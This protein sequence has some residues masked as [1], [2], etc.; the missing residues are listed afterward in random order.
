MDGASRCGPLHPITSA[1]LAHLTKEGRPHYLDEHLREVGELAAP[2]R[3]E[4]LESIGT[5]SM[6]NVREA[7]LS[8]LF[9]Q[10]PKALVFTNV[11]RPV[12]SAVWEGSPV[13]P[14]PAD[15]EH[16]PIVEVLRQT[17]VLQA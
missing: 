14:R 2:A 12:N 6:A 13:R 16:Q 7:P 8:Q 9:A 17:Q 11:Q 1:P 5:A 4:T 10:R 3:H 15:P